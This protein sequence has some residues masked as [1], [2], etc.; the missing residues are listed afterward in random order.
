MPVPD[1][2]P[3]APP[4]QGKRL[5]RLAAVQALYQSGYQQSSPAQIVQDSVANGFAGLRGDDDG[6][7]RLDGTPDAAL[8]RAIVEGVAADPATLD[9]AIAGAL[10][11]RFSAGRL[12]LLLRAILRAGVYELH[13]HPE[14]P[15]GIIINDYVDVARSFFSG[16]EPGLVNGILDRAGKALRGA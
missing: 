15:A 1:P 4:S 3:K 8:F 10:D 7:G 6:A 5:A 14:I 13:R 11:P 2:S 9:S 16:K 12:E